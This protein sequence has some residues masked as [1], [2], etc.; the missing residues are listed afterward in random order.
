MRTGKIRAI[1]Q[2]LSAQPA[3][4]NCR[5]TLKH[6]WNRSPKFETDLRVEGVPQY[7]I[8][9]AKEQM[10]EINKMSEKLKSGSCTKSVRDDLEKKGDMIFS[11]VSS[12]VIYEMGSMELFELR[13]IS[14][15]AQC[16][17]CLKHVPEGL[18][19]CGCGVSV[20]PDEATINR[21]KA[22]FPVLISTYYLARVNHSKRKETRRC[23]M[24]TRSSESN[25]AMRGARKHDQD[26]NHNQVATR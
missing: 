5:E 17:S 13:Q 10:K 14:V 22:R 26:T 8:L 19:F 18:Q 16:H 1:Q 7:A 4:G 21:I 3:S 11:E 12:R 2:M 15:T 25:D 9:K 6:V 23:S 24:A 20:R